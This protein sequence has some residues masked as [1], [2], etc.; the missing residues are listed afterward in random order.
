MILLLIGLIFAESKLELVRV[1][2]SISDSFAELFE[3]VSNSCEALDYGRG[4]TATNQLSEPIGLFDKIPSRLGFGH[5]RAMSLELPLEFGIESRGSSQMQH[6]PR[7]VLRVEALEMHDE[8][9]QFTRL[10]C[11]Y[12][13]EV[14][15]DAVEFLT[16]QS[17]RRVS[18]RMDRDEFEVSVGAQIVNTIELAEYELQLVR[19]RKPFG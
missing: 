12:V 5:E 13:E 14:R 11:E 18:V 6:E 10:T 19:N 15:N 8:T 3:I 9:R 1:G 2:V 7:V 17:G 4:N 16:R